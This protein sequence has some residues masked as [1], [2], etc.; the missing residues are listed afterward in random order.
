MSQRHLYF[1]DLSLENE[2]K[3]LEKITMPLAALSLQID[4]KNKFFDKEYEVDT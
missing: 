2:R 4:F 1:E 3:V